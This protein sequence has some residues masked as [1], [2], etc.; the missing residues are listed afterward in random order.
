MS[1]TITQSNTGTLM[2]ATAETATVID[3][4][5][6]Y[7]R[8]ITDNDTV[9]ESARYTCTAVENIKNE[10]YY[11]SIFTKKNE[12]DS[13]I[14]HYEIQSKDTFARTDVSLPP[15]WT[16]NDW[17]PNK[18]LEG[19]NTTVHLILGNLFDNTMTLT[20]ESR[21]PTSQLMNLE[22][23]YLTVTMT[24]KVSLKDTAIRAG[25]PSNIIN[26]IGNSDIYQTFL[27]TY[28]KVDVNGGPSSIGIVSDAAVSVPDKY[29]YYYL[30]PGLYDSYEGSTADSI[31]KP[32]NPEEGK[33]YASSPIITDNY[34]E[35][36]NNQNLVD[37]IGYSAYSYGVTI[38]TKFDLVYEE[39]YMS[40]QFTKKNNEA[41]NVG[42]SVIGYSH[43]SSS[44]KG[45]ANSATFDKETNNTRY[46]T[47]DESKAS[48]TY[49]VVETKNNIYGDYSY[50]GKN[51]VN[52]GDTASL[53]KSEA[54]YD[55]TSLKN[56]G[57]YVELTLTLSKRDDYVEPSV[58]DPTAD[59]TTL[60][61]GTYLTE[62]TIKGA[63]N[64]VIF[65]QSKTDA[66]QSNENIKVTTTNNIYTIRAKKDQLQTNGEGRYVFPI[67]YKVYTGDGLFNE[68]AGGLE[69]SNYKVSLTAA[70]YSGLDTAQ[71][72]YLA[73]SYTY[74]HLIYTNARVEEQVIP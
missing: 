27:M 62:L 6:N 64:D 39:K 11:L 51:A 33:Q 47:A 40:Y 26:N 34:I 52:L 35:L 46:Y 41:D 23:N 19:A 31:K 72:T 68:N 7:Y 56:A 25:I 29:Y 71:N 44:Q 17:R 55:V 42:S 65:D 60:P 38:Q 22:N 24:S 21:R 49:N 45:A 36:R 59:G 53:V 58:G 57:D 37:Y 13:N 50:L 20:V 3:K 10:R 18:V 16:V 61:I 48:L 73:P 30:K 54:I 74:D 5:G 66:Q 2:E 70:T 32:E 28:D 67:E 1:A 69:Y 4:L 8:P 9:A 14:Y 12:N 15:R 63:G 43:I